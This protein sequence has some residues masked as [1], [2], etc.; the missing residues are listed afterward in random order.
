MSIQEL[1]DLIE[2]EV[3]PSKEFS[4]EDCYSNLREEEEEEE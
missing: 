4:I 1:Q 2:V 3:E